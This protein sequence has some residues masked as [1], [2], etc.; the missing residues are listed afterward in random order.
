M[1]VLSKLKMKRSSPRNPKTT[2]DSGFEKLV[3]RIEDFDPES[4][5][6]LVRYAHCGTARVGIKY[7]VGE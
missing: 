6:C 1:K 4:F 7:V 2:N 5:R 3:I